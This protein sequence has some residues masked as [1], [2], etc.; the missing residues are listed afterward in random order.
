MVVGHLVKA[1]MSDDDQTLSLYV[2]CVPGPRWCQCQRPGI[3][4]SLHT[5]LCCCQ[6]MPFCD[7]CVLFLCVR[8]YTCPVLC[9]SYYQMYRQSRGHRCPAPGPRYVVWGPPRPRHPRSHQTI[10]RP[11]SVSICLL[12]LDTANTMSMWVHVLCVTTFPQH[13]SHQSANYQYKQVTETKQV[14]PNTNINQ[15]PR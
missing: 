6:M 3:I 8:V 1:E 11:Q 15:F 4:S 12:W 7:L 13:S 5:L 9:Y 14:P 2:V 10:P